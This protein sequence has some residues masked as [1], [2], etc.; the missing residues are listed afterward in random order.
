VYTGMQIILRDRRYMR[1][2][3]N[4]DPD[5]FLSEYNA[6]HQVDLLQGGGGNHF[7]FPIPVP[8]NGAAR[9][10]MCDLQE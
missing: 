7:P 2:I 1:N 8:S 3:A 6:I 5:V 9:S 4:R 10:L